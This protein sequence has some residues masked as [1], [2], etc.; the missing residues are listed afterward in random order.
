MALED[1]DKLLT[2]PWQTG[3]LHVQRSRK[4][5][6]KLQQTEHALPHPRRSNGSGWNLPGS[7][8]L[9]M[10]SDQLSDH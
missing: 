8:C 2:A 4:G 1:L 3:C 10:T 9:S 7:R 5:K 6:Y